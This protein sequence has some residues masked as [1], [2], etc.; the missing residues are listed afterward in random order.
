MLHPVTTTRFEKDYVRQHKRGK[1]LSK[2]KEIMARIVREGALPSKNRDHL[3][4]GNWSKYREC[5]VEPD[6]LLIYR[7]DGESVVFERTGTH[8]D[9]F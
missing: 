5:H 9:L 8:A 7:I 2:L 6:W 1:E 3:L 4:A